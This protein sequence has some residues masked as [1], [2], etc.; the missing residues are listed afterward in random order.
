MK[1]KLLTGFLLFAGL[2]LF[3]TGMYWLA[4]FCIILS[5]TYYFLF[6]IGIWNKVHYYKWLPTIL[7]FSGIIL[8][9]I[10]IRIFFFSIYAISSGSMENTL[11]PGDKILVNKLSFGPELPRSTSEIPWIGLLLYGNKRPSHKKHVLWGYKRL[12]GYTKNCRG[13][14]MVFRHPIWGG[15]TNFFIK[16][17]IAIPGDTVSI[18]QT[19][20]FVNQKFIPEPLQVKKLYRI[21]TNKPEKL[22]QLK[23]SIGIEIINISTSQSDKPF[24]EIQLTSQQYQKIVQQHFVDS[25]KLRI[26]SREPKRWVY[27]NSDEFAWTVDD[28]GPLIIPFKG[29]TVVLNSKNFKLYQ[30]TINCLEGHSLH[31]KKGLYY[32]NGVSVDHY[33]F[34]NNY[35][36]MMGDNRNNSRDSREW[37]LVPDE[38]IVGKAEFI[39]FSNDLNG[40]KWS[41]FFKLI[42]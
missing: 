24:F 18:K 10:C 7:A 37:G 11:I 38:N 14:V 36:Y 27:P 21:W 42:N 17:C 12:N 39:L 16:R 23:D 41:R 19:K 32:L 30:R 9:T 3:L 13:N 25:I 40:F 6:C 2:L 29:F 34:K 1:N 5:I 35:Y 20:L 28:Y 15:R 22:Y 31:E 33:A 26:S 8:I 4:I